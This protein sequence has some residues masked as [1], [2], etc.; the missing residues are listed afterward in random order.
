[1]ESNLANVSLREEESWSCVLKESNLDILLKKWS[2]D[3]SPYL[4]GELPALESGELGTESS[5]LNGL[6][7]WNMLSAWGDPVLPGLPNSLD[8]KKYF[9]PCLS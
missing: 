1:M 3:A 5:N 6:F 4:G 2:P 7:F 8:S 9:S